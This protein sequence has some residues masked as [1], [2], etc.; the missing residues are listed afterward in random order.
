[1]GQMVTCQQRHLE[2]GV[3]QYSSGFDEDEYLMLVVGDP[4]YA[5][6]NNV[7]FLE[8]QI[9]KKDKATGHIIRLGPTS[10]PGWLIARGT[11]NRFPTTCDSRSAIES[12]RPTSLP[13]ASACSADDVC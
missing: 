7:K 12:T 3:I 2:V 5:R 11:S 6:W 4:D 1:M 13:S 9:V 8:A 10:V